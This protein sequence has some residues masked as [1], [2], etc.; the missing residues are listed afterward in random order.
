[1]QS[2]SSK[3]RPGLP[4][5]L[6]RSALNSPQSGFLEDSPF[7]DDID[8]LIRCFDKTTK[9]RFRNAEE[10]QYI[11]FGSTRDN[12]AKYNIRFG[13]LKVAGSDVA[14]FFE[15]SINCIIKSVLD[16]RKTSH[17]NISHVVLV[18]GFAASDWLFTKVQ[19]GLSEH[20]LNV[21]RPENHVNKAVSDGAISFYLDHFVRT[22]VSKLSY[23]TFCGTLYEE[24]DPEHVKRKANT[25]TNLAGELLVNNYFAVILQ[26]N[27][28]ITESKEF[29]YSLVHN[30]R[31]VK[32]IS[33]PFSC[34]RGDLEDPKWK[35]LD[36]D[37]FSQLCVVIVDLSHLT[38]EP[39]TSHKNETYYH[40]KYDVVLMFGLTEVT[41]QVAWKENGVEKR[42]DA[43]IVYDPDL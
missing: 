13:Q 28:Q 24:T 31:N 5:P 16:Q 10:P 30:T 35:D 40:V 38:L 7:A 39:L 37:N 26:K 42:S 15:P 4:N 32:A 41:A 8:H 19:E 43:K 21:M 2:F 20:G 23:G 36:P 29:R 1:M 34:Y 3:V 25:Y 6:L 9:P 14:K 17:S 22:R 33:V 18:G 12:D 27:T 11:K